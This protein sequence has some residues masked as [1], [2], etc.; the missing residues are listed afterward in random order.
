MQ[1]SDTVEMLSAAHRFCNELIDNTP[2]TL[3]DIVTLLVD[4]SILRLFLPWHA[5]SKLHK[6]MRAKLVPN[7]SE[8][9]GGKEA[10]CTVP[11]C[12]WLY[13]QEKLSTA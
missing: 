1:S 10:D 13:G 3:G 12:D 11:S 6:E 7:P 8:R 5:G 4:Q 2:D 9:S